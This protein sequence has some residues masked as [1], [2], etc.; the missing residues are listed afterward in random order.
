MNTAEIACILRR[1]LDALCVR[2]EGVFAADTIGTIRKYPTCFVVNTDA[3]DKPGEHWVACYAKSQSEFE[4]FDSYG[5]PAEAYSHL[6]LPYRISSYNDVSLQAID[7]YACGHFCI[8]YLCMRARGMSLSRIVSRLS[9]TKPAR[10]D[11]LVRRYVFRITTILHIKRPCR[12]A[13]VGLQCCG[14]RVQ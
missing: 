5:M 9:C 1:Y 10:R 12:D 8:Y 4:F 7:S 3:A 6:R 13:C 11:S 2:F 14:K